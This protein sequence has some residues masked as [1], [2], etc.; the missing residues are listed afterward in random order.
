MTEKEI[1]IG[2]LTHFR[3]KDKFS[4][5]AWE[6][7]GLNPSDSEMCAH[8]QNLFNNCADALIEGIH[9]DL[10]QGELKG[11]LKK[12]LGTLQRSDYD[13]EER[14][15]ICDY[16]N[17][18][19]KIVSVNFNNNLNDWLYGKLLSNLLKV[20]SY[21]KGK[22]KPVDTLTQNCTQCQAAFETIILK[23]EEGI[24]RLILIIQCNQCREFNLISLGPNIKEMRFGEY[25]LIEQL[26]VEEFSE[27]QA[28]TR[29]EQIKYFRRK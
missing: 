14:E 8:L 1:K 23:I 9:A 25:T 11:I 7:R 13:T 18:I 27:E 6:Q 17:Q 28:I 26:P 29:L 22:E 20:T 15:I 24:P 21:L 3:N 4:N 12:A 19:S 5:A 16:F 10:K 2:H